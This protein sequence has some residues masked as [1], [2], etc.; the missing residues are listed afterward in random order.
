MDSNDSTTHV[1]ENKRLVMVRS[2]LVAVANVLPLPG[3]SELLVDLSRRGLVEHLAREH[4]VELDA[5]VSSVL[6]EEAPA[7]QRLGIL[8]SLSK[9]GTLLRRQKQ[10]RRLFTGLQVLNAA[11]AGFRA[12]ELGTL[13][14]HYLSTYH[15]GQSLSEDQARTVRKTLLESC[16]S[17]EQELLSDAISGLAMAIGQ[18]ALALPGYVW[19]RVASQGGTAL[20]LPEL[21]ALTQSAQKL[22]SD[23]R[24]QNYAKKLTEHFDRKWSGPAVITVSQKPN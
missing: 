19:A 11:E 4:R 9:L 12:F 13:F 5:G 16:R 23:L 18:V 14:D 6:L 22:L 8:S 2:V 1:G 20:T 15:M 24:L 7:V 3:V 21:H 17:T 10:L